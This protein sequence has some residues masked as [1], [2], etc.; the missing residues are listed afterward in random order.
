MIEEKLVLRKELDVESFKIIKIL[1][2]Q[3]CDGGNGEF[4]AP[5]D[6]LLR[7]YFG[8]IKE[9]ETFDLPYIENDNVI[10]TNIKII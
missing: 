1:I 3:N 9:W 5:L 7:K 4:D 6:I 8:T 2:S 10:I